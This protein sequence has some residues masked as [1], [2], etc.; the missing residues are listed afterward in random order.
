M[1][2]IHVTATRET[3]TINN[4]GG[5]GSLV[6]IEFVYVKAVAAKKRLYRKKLLCIFIILIV[7]RFLLMQL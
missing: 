4:G 5:P 1:I 6:I 7:N 2:K 3:Q